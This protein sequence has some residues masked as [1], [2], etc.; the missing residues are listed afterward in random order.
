MTH[1]EVK[2]VP[3]KKIDP[4]KISM[5]N[6]QDMDGIQQ[7]AASMK[8]LGLIHPIILTPR[9]DR[10]ETIAG[11]RRTQ[12]AALLKW[13]E[14]PARI[15]TE[16]ADILE[17]LKMHENL[18][19]IDVTPL[20]EAE[21]LDALMQTHHISQKEL[22][23]SI[24]RSPAYVCERL[25]MLNYPDELKAAVKDGSVPYSAAR[26]LIKIRDDDTRQ[27][28]IG[29]AVSGGINERT[30]ADWRRTANQVSNIN[31]I[32]AA[33]CNPKPTVHNATPDGYQCS[34]CGKYHPLDQTVM[35]RMCHPCWNEVDKAAS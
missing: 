11:H 16:T 13:T 22:A 15:I 1:M 12:A 30:A 26:E 35:A 21:F 10:Y 28:Y 17:A 18:M 19:R 32:P 20:E 6:N 29:H 31:D 8:K 34:L 5:R 33:P 14:I 2:S 24:G 25:A 3:I 23:A 7:L 9:E 27:S 4:P